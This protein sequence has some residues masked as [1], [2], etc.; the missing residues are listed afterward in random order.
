MVES[1]Y[2]GCSIGTYSCIMGVQ[3]EMSAFAKEHT[4]YFTLSYDYIHQISLV[5]ETLGKNVEQLWKWIKS[6]DL[7]V[8]DFWCFSCFTQQL[9][10][11]SKVKRV[12][13]WI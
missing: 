4:L 6:N 1:L 3:I 10:L 5:D 2:W 11:L 8:L 9:S 7:P 13:L 12:Y